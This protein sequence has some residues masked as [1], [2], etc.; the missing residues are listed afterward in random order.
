MGPKQRQCTTWVDPE[1]SIL[2]M[3]PR[4]CPEAAVLGWPAV[5]D[6]GPLDACVSPILSY[7]R[8]GA[9]LFSIDN[10]LI[11]PPGKGK[12]T[13]PKPSDLPKVTFPRLLSLFA[14]EI[15]LK[16]GSRGILSFSKVLPTYHKTRSSKKGAQAWQTWHRPS[17]LASMATVTF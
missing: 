7:G 6:A 13:F 17:T 12:V 5:L 10:Y 3:S 2:L 15:P 14:L 11:F 1:L 9:E 16:T 8:T 4:L